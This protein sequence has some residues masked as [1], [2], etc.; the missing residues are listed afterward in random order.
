MCSSD[1]GGEAS[2]SGGQV[3]P[4]LG[5]FSTPAL[6]MAFRASFGVPDDVQVNLVGQRVEGVA[7]VQHKEGL[8]LIPLMAVFEG[9]VRFPLH[10][11]LVS[12]LRELGTTT[13]MFTVN[14]FCIVMSLV[15]LN[16]RHNLR[17]TTNECFGMYAINW[18]KK[19]VRYFPAIRKGKEYVVDMFPD[20][21]QWGGIFLSVTGN[22]APKTVPF[23]G[24]QLP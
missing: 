19:T 7:A 6:Q 4:F 16:E 15:R 8:L 21:D 11:F 12:I 13:S 18:N 2:S 1:L 9:G 24:A 17:L 14:F 20:A 23:L 10:P 5:H 22:Y 3:C